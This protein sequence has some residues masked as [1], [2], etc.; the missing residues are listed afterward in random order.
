MI[1]P[2]TGSAPTVRGNERSCKASTIVTFS[3]AI[4]LN[5]ETIFGFS[6]SG[7]G[8]SIVPHCTYGPYRPVLRNTSSPSSSPIGSTYFGAANKATAISTFNSSGV[9]VSGTDAVLS[10]QRT[11]GPN[12]PGRRTI[13]S[14]V[15]GCM[16]TGN[17]FKAAASML[18]MLCSTSGFNPGSSLPLP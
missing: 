15:V 2:S 7:G 9:I 5:S 13:S 3:S 16:P 12:L 6:K 1:S 11:Y 8:F 14:P 10:P 17:A 18:A 4:V